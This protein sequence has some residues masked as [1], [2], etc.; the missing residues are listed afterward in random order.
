MKDPI[1]VEIIAEGLEAAAQEML[2]VLQ[3]TAMS[4]IVYEVLDAGAGITDAAGRLVASGAGIP[5]FVSIIDRAV[6]AVHAHFGEDIRPG[7]IFLTNEPSQGGVTHLNDVAAVMPVY[8][9]GRRVAWVGVIAHWSD[10]GGGVA[11]SMMAGA[12]EL[13]QEGIRIPPIKVAE[14]GK[15]LTHVFRLLKTNSRLPDFLE[16]DLWAQIAA[17]KAGERRVRELA[18]RYGYEVFVDTLNEILEAGY[19]RALQGLANLPQGDFA[20]EEEQDDGSCFRVRVQIRPDQFVVDLRDNPDQMPG[21]YNLYR[22]ATEIA[23][24]MIFKALVDPRREGANA[25]FFR[26]LKVITRPGSLFDAL[27]PAACGFYYELRM[28]VYDLIWRCLATHHPALLPAGHFATIGGTVLSGR[29]PDNQKAYVLVEPQPGGWGAFWEGDGVSTLF[30]AFHGETY[31]CPAEVAEARYGLEVERMALNE[32]K[33]GEGRYRGGKGFVRVYRMRAEA[34]LTVGFTRTRIP[35]WG[36]AGGGPGTPN[37]VEIIYP[38]GSIRR[39]GI[40]SGVR[41]PPGA[42]VRIVTGVGGGYGARGDSEG[43]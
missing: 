30:S 28:R 16:G 41:L 17:L 31:I 42:R 40:A 25:G 6:R 32:E 14:G 8:A 38:D 19:K 20:L 33:G 36:L 35:P 27:P 21:P 39:L 11:G 1:T 15:I 29:N 13:F 23:A 7:D 24:Q 2:L 18:R 43:R 26:P 4:P 10:V 22:D 9:I 5:T 12:G 37:R 3:R 34:L